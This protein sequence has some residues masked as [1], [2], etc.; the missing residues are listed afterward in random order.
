MRCDNC[1]KE[2]DRKVFCCDKCRIRYF[3]KKHKAIIV[4]KSNVTEIVKK[5]PVKENW[6]E[7]KK[8]ASFL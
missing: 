5:L 2:I 7:I 6:E 3:R 1:E 4:T 8:R